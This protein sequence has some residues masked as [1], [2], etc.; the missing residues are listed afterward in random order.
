MTWPIQWRELWEWAHQPVAKQSIWGTESR[1][2]YGKLSH[3]KSLLIFYLQK[4]SVKQYGKPAQWIMAAR[5]FPWF[6]D[7]RQGCSVF[8]TL[9]SAH[10]I[11]DK[12]CHPKRWVN[13]NMYTTP[14]CKNI[15]LVLET[16]GRPCHGPLE[17]VGHLPEDTNL[18]RKQGNTRLVPAHLPQTVTSRVW[19]TRLVRQVI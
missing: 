18:S 1:N 13:T 16:G 14:W 10:R 19:L 7:I 2:I 3:M 17:R 11:D 12:Q 6:T 9:H 5:S 4:T 15:G 8:Q